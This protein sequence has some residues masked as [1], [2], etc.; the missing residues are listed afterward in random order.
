MF[1][2]DERKFYLQVGGECMITNQ[3][4]DAKE[5]KQFWS[6]IWEQKE[7]GKKAE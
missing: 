2:N 4:P 1:Q 3:Q 6:K 7:H 5:A